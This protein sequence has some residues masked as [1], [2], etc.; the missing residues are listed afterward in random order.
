LIWAADK[1]LKGFFNKC[2]GNEHFLFFVTSSTSKCSLTKL[3][4][5][6]TIFHTRVVRSSHAPIYNPVISRFICFL[7]T[8]KSAHFS[9]SQVHIATTGGALIGP[10]RCSVSGGGSFACMNYAV[11]SLDFRRYCNTTPIHDGASSD[12]KVWHQ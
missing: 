8:N 12:R 5:I 6:L 3:A 4:W 1:P 7:C 11:C 10:S 2:N 9:H